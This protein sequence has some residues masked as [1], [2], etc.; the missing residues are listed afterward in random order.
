MRIAEHCLGWV[1]PFGNPR[2]TASSS[3]PGLIAASHVLHRLWAPR[4]PPHT[5]RNL[6]ATIPALSSSSRRR[7]LRFLTP[8]D[9]MLTRRYTATHLVKEQCLNV[10]PSPPGHGVLYRIWRESQGPFFRGPPA[11]PAPRA[12]RRRPHRPS[13]HLLRQPA[14]PCP[15]RCAP[16][17]RHAA[18]A[19]PAPP[20]YSGRAGC[21]GARLGRSLFLLALRTRA[22]ALRAL[23]VRLGP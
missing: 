21:L 2:I 15:T 4:H 10:T 7:P 6:T 18:L 8:A 1:A 12:P 13:H 16:E 19:R 17:A 11:P 22:A 5:L 23:R 9:Q 3:S 20:R 14:P